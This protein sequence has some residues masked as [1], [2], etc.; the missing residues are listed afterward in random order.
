VFRIGAFGAHCCQTFEEKTARNRGYVGGFLVEVLE[1]KN[2][3]EAGIYKFWCATG[4][5]FTG[6]V[7][8]SFLGI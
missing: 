4:V 6:W 7:D 1:T 5:L 8:G 3:R 2:F